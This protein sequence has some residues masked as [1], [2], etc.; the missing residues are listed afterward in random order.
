MIPIP[1]SE[2][3]EEMGGWATGVLYHSREASRHEDQLG[4]ES[5]YGGAGM[6]RTKRE[7]RVVL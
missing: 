6:M 7:M 4:R 5:V 2:V 1:T 3:R